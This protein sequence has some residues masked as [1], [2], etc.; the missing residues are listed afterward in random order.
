MA[1]DEDNEGKMIS[2]NA[3]TAG[4]AAAGDFNDTDSVDYSL[5]TRDDAETVLEDIKDGATAFTTGTWE[6][7]GKQTKNRVR[8][9]GYWYG[10]KLR[11]N[12]AGETFAMD[13][14]YCDVI[15]AGKE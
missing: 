10:L 9:R 12:T 13:K 8:M 5:F 15:S 11:N 6:G 4:G 14:T 7:T 2:I 3:I 1:Q